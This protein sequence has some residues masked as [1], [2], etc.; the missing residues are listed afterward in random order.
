MAQPLR[1]TRGPT[2]YRVAPMEE[3]RADSPH[4]QRA[5]PNPV[6]AAAEIASLISA[7]RSGRKNLAEFEH[8]S[9]TEA[10]QDRTQ[11]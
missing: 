8:H 1:P 3:V 2:R 6:P 5:N 4:R 10:D 7:V 9:E 11:E